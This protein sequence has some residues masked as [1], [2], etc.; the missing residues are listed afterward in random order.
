[1]E[2]RHRFALDL[3]HPIAIQLW[4]RDGAPV[5]SAE[6]SSPNL[7]PGAANVEVDVFGLR[8]SGYLPQQSDSWCTASLGKEANFQAEQEPFCQERGFIF[9]VSTVKTGDYLQR[10]PSEQDEGLALTRICRT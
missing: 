5:E 10:V 6:A 2:S 3:Q 9:L 1:M 8:R 7:Q 4:L